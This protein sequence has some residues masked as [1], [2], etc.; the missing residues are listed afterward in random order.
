MLGSLNEQQMN[1][2]LASQVVGRLACTDTVQ[3]YLVPVTYAFDG[4]TI[5]GQT[6]EG[7]KL[8]LLRKNPNVCFE[9]DVMH[10]MANWQSVIIRGRFEELKDEAAEKA[11]TVLFNRVFPLMTSATVH[12]EHHEVDHELDDE[13]RIKPIM[14]KIV[15]EEKTG[16]FEKR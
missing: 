2:L 6:N 7:M 11:R 14:Y 5:Y 13:N 1:N 12:G 15:I 16:R 9:V 4:V 8:S 10:D 3:P